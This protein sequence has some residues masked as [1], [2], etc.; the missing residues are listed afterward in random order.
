MPI[1]I[2]DDINSSDIRSV[3]LTHIIAVLEIVSEVV[4]DQSFAVAGHKQL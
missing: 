1:G 3:F 4:T 2:P